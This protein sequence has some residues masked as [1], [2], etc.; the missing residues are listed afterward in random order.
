MTGRLY[1]GER[2]KV[3]RC[4]LNCPIRT[5][6][7]NPYLFVTEANPNESYRENSKPLGKQAKGRSTSDIK[8]QVSYT[9]LLVL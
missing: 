6:V 4:L 3:F 2:F 7:R 8:L 5:Y 1:R 9:T